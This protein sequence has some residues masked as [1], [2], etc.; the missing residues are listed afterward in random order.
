MMGEAA[1]LTLA[2][3]TTETPPVEAPADSPPAE[4]QPPAAETVPE[5]EA[6]ADPAPTAGDAP[7]EVPGEVPGEAPAEAEEGLIETIIDAVTEAV[8]EVIPGG[9]GETAGEAEVEVPV[10]GVGIA[11]DPGAAADDHEAI[12]PE[13]WL[14]LALLALIV[15]AIRP[16]KRAILGALDGRAGRIREE[17]EEAQRLREEAQAA[18]ANFQRRQR[19]AMGE[20]EEIIAH[21]RAEAERLREHAAADLEATLERREALAMERIAQAEAA[22]TSEVRAIAVDVAIAA[23]RDAIAANLDSKKADALVDQA[24]KDLPSKLH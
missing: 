24:I 14:V 2:Q 6:A 9:E 21:A 15:I 11:D 1:V 7:G 5:P 19:D 20:A 4:T 10:E 3:A 22:A 13:I 16:A 18:L 8:E 12:A 23:A 17:L